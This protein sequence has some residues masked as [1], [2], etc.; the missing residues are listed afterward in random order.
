LS[1]RCPDC[2]QPRSAQILYR[3]NQV[4]ST[5]IDEI[6]EGVCPAIEPIGTQAIEDGAGECSKVQNDN[7]REK[8]G[9]GVIFFR[10]VFLEEQLSFQRH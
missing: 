4:T 2:T 9:E 5:E 8:V 7:F 1:K 10:V 3:L 6:R